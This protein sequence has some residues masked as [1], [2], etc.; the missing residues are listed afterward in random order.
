[1]VRNFLLQIAGTPAYIAPEII[2]EKGYGKP[3]DWWA[4]GIVLYQF[5]LGDVPFDGCKLKEVLKQVLTR[6]N[7]NFN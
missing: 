7:N 2:L 5:L 4:V 3:V 1:M 6:K